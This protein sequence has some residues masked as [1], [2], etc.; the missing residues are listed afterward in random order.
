MNIGYAC[1]AIAVP[2]TSLKTCMLKNADADRLLSLIASNLDALARL[3]DYNARCGIKLFRIS[4]DLIPFGSS[5]A[6]A[7]PWQS[8]YAQKLSDIG[9]RI[10]GRAAQRGTEQRMVVGD[11]QL[12]HRGP[13]R[14]RGRGGRGTR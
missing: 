3:I 12:G 9:R 4:S 11:Q 7:L 1:L 8:V 5:A 14:H 10:A 2:G 13:V 6:F